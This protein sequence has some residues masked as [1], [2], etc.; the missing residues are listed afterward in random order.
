MAIAVF[1]ALHDGYCCVSVLKIGQSN[2]QDGLFLA[3]NKVMKGAPKWP[4][5]SLWVY[6][7]HLRQCVLVIIAVVGD[8]S[9]L[10]NI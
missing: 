4:R 7:C 5:G 9:A 10:G 2:K 1:T 8:H 3:G 6:L